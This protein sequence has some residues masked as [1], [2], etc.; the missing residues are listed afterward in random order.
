MKRI[1]DIKIIVALLLTAIL[2]FSCSQDE[3]NIPQKGVLEL[4]AFYANAN[5]DDVTS[6]M[7]S[8]YKTVFAGIRSA[9]EWYIPV[10][11][12]SDDCFTGSAFTDSDNMQ[13]FAN[14]N[15]VTTNTT[16]KSIYQQ[17]YMVIYWCNLLINKVTADT[18]VKTRI[19]AEA[20]AVRAF[21]YIDLIRLWGNPV[22]VDNVLSSDEAGNAP[23]T[24]AEETWLLVEQDLKDA[25]NVLPSKSN[26]EGQAAIGGRL[27]AEAAKALLG[28]AQ[29]WQGKYAEAV[30]TLKQ[31]ITSGLYDLVDMDA[32]HRPA[33]DFGAEY[34]WEFNAADNAANYM[35]QGDM[36]IAFLGWR[37]DNVDSDAAGLVPA[38]WGFGAV[39]AD[40][41]RFLLSHDGGKSPRWKAWVADYEDILAMGSTGVWA[42]PVQ[43]NQGYFR[44]ARVARKEDLFT[45]Q[46]T[47][48]ML[49]RSKA[50]EAWI[51]YAEVL[52]LYAEAQ[53][54]ANNDSDGS[55]L[56]AIN[57]IRQRAGIPPLASYGLQE[58]KDEKRAEMFFEGERYFDLVRWGDA[59]TMLRDKGKKWYSFYGYVDGTTSWDVRE[60]DGPGNGWSEKNKYLPFP[61]DEITANP[62]LVQNQGW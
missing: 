42:P 50:N 20:K 21:C 12:L 23:N 32:V 41:A 62:G 38:T 54:V 59:A 28:K 30:A 4:D 48:S 36:R 46:F 55:G 24:P 60:M 7:A 53:I 61:A 49:A 2:S 1:K 31:I 45:L 25:V 11:A 44:L 10:N 47:W 43:N 18:D 22:K 14:Y 34:L 40:F 37:S 17:H 3:F 15:I 56:A 35:D 6:A 27:T 51:R 9:T 58:L 19:I 5:D 57:R 26:R 33:A 52:L 13:Q 39:T 29:L 8:I 16:V